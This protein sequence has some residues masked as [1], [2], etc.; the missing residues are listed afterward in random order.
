MKGA[1][2]LGLV[3]AAL[4]AG[5]GG[6]GGGGGGFN[7]I[8]AELVPNL[9]PLKAQ[10]FSISLEN[11]GGGSVQ[12]ILRLASLVANFGAG[13]IEIYG[14]IEG[15]DHNDL[16]PAFQRIR[17]NN[18]DITQIPA[19]EFEH[20]NVHNHWHW[21]NLVSFTLHEAA[22]MSDPYDAANTV[23]ATT[24]KVS[25]CL[26]DTAK[27][28]G[29]IGPNQPS[30]R[31]Y[32]SCGQNTQGISVGW[33]DIY[34]AQLYGQWIV[35]D[36]VPDGVYWVILETDPTG[37]LTETDET[38]NRSAVKIQITGNSVTVIP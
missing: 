9:R 8:P 6:S 12:K 4:A 16:V 32:R 13:P 37:L 7:G 23:V 30:S 29:F 36:G 1:R 22:N 11:I 14:E 5:C 10:D 28:P 17:W 31:R 21:E 3:A 38:D 19:G 15:A 35:I 25:F 18:G 24:P 26:L 33:Y 27:I 34:S 20:H 2:V